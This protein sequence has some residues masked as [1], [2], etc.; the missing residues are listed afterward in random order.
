MC[1]LFH[2]TWL[3][4]LLFLLTGALL[5]AL[6]G[7][8]S[9]LALP[10]FLVALKVPLD[11]AVPATAA[12]VGVA[13]LSGAWD[14]WR[15]RQ[16]DLRTLLR[17]SLPAVILSAIG[18]LASSWIPTAILHWTFFAILLYAGARMFLPARASESDG[19][20]LANH[21]RL[22]GAGAGTGLLMGLFGVG[23]GFIATP[24]LVLEGGLTTA[25]AIPVAL[26]AI[27]LSA[28][29]S[30]AVQIPLGTFRWSL[31]VPAVVAALAGMELGRGIAR[32]VSAVWL[33]RG[34]GVLVLVAAAGLA[35]KR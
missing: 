4:T 12:V 8:G 3:S 2:F 29:A 6:G 27:A 19:N 14:A 17:F 34:M 28:A 24:A 18:S 15:E 5:G 13:S 23:G 33:R 35:V 7:G 16:L 25:A 30:L 20:R 31:V 1:P 10:I 9:L 26:G 22:T 11:V 21:L 32:R